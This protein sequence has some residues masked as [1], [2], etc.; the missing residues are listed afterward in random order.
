MVVYSAGSGQVA[1][2]GLGERDP[3]RN[4]LFAR[5]FA[6][7]MRTPGV[8]V[9]ELMLT[10][11]ESVERLAA[12]VNHAQRPAIYDE[13]RGRFVFHAVPAPAPAPTLAPAPAPTPAAQP[14]GSGLPGGYRAKSADVIEDELWATF[15]GSNSRTGFA[16]YLR[17]YPAGRYA[18]A[19]RV[20]LEVLGPIDRD[21]TTSKA[22]A[23]AP[24]TAARPVAPSGAA[25]K[26]AAAP[27]PAVVASRNSIEPPPGAGS[28][29]SLNN[30]RFRG[31]DGQFEL[32]VR[33][34]KEELV[35]EKFRMVS[36]RYYGT[37]LR[38]GTFRSK[39]DLD[40]QLNV[41]AWCNGAI[42]SALRLAGRFP[43]IDI[44]TGG[45]I[46]GG[47]I[48]LTEIGEGK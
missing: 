47:T 7:E 46:A 1:L 5:E 23:A 38:C 39:I 22:A 29:D 45:A 4:G 30:K 3:I 33:A 32:T 21:G 6:R 20:Q 44:Y 16:A 34:A 26:P 43:R 17:E 48:D 37:V 40:E 35:V 19:A 27:P 9:R 18:A 41:S 42:P 14:G 8:D 10:V 36:A 31:M 11:R 2:D 15:S 12:S 24:E 28:R 25:P 13:S